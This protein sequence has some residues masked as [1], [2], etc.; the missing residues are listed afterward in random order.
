MSTSQRS[1]HPSLP[2]KPPASTNDSARAFSFKPRNIVNPAS[3][4]SYSSPQPVYPSAFA[5]PPSS[6]AAQPGYHAQP[7]PY[8]YDYNQ[9]SPPQ[10]LNPFAAPG[11][12]PAAGQSGTSPAGASGYNAEEAA[13]IAQWQSAYANNSDQ[14]ANKFVSHSSSGGAVAPSKQ[15][16]QPEKKDDK[17]KTVVRSGGGET[18]QDDSLLEWDPTHP[19]FFVGNLAGE[20][21]DDSL[22]KAFAKYTSV[23]KARVVRDKRTTKSKG[24]GFIS[25]SNAEEFQRAG[26][27][28]QGRYIGSHPIILRRAKTDVKA[29]NA[30]DKNAKNRGKAGNAGGHGKG[31]GS[32]GIQKQKKNKGGLDILG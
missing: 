26:K 16:Q 5:P 21:S 14:P 18:W 3:P 2:Q 17:K 24:Y 6:F 13:A 11:Q 4:P 22:L 8:N 10:I 20:V 28:M 7:Q 19:R 23:V 15:E 30:P 25:F 27:E 1:A 12:T 9:A 31:G 29:S 32:G